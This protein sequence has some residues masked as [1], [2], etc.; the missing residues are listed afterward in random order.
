MQPRQV[1][2]EEWEVVLTGPESYA[3]EAFM[4]SFSKDA[5]EC[6]CMLLRTH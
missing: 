3:T 2:E 4:K 5:E 6:G 1:G